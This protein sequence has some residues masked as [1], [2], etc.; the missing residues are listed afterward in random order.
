MTCPTCGREHGCDDPGH[1]MEECEAII[2]KLK[3]ELAE[4]VAILTDMANMERF[5]S[6]NEDRLDAI[7]AFLTKHRS[8]T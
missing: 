7:D 5:E 8:T 1:T 6:I 4:A 2:A 3:A